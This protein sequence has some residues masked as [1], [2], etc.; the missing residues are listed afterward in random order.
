MRFGIAIELA[1]EPVTIFGGALGQMVDEGFNLIASRISQSGGAAIVGGIG[2]DEASIEMVLANQ[3]AEAVAE[4]RLAALRT[5]ISVRGN[6]AMF[7]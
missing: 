3:Q 7:G 6:L 5:F 1:D 2:L 4:A